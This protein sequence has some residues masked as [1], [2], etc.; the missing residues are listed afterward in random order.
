MSPTKAEKKGGVDGLLRLHYTPRIRAP[1]LPSQFVGIFG[2]LEA[3]EMTNWK[4]QESCERNTR[5]VVSSRGEEQRR[6]IVINQKHKIKQ[7]NSTQAKRCAKSSKRTT[8]GRRAKSSKRTTPGIPTWSPTVV[9]AWP[10]SA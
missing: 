6:S 4:N 1:F 8:P 5:K 2:S 9:L 3:R 7:H 10:D